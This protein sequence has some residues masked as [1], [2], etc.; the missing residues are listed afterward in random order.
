MPATPVRGGQRY[1]QPEFCSTVFSRLY[2]HAS[3]MQLKNSICHGEAN[4][5]ASALGR[6]IKVK[7]L[8]PDIIR[9][10]DSLVGDAQHGHFAVG[11]ERHF[12]LATVGHGLGAVLDYVQGGL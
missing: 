11:F 9:N 6:E 5:A 12:Q 10:A 4:S 3:M 2:F 1:A 8:F 7:N